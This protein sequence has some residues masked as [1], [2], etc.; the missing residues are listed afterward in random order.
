MPALGRSLGI[1]F[2]TGFG[3]AGPPSGDAD[4]DDWV[5]RVVAAG[6]TVPAATKTA[7]ATFVTAA[8]AHGYW[9][10][11]NRI[12]LFAGGE[13]TACLIP[14]K[15]G[16]GS[17]AEQNVGPF[18]SGDYTQA[19]GLTGNGTTKY[20]RTNLNPGGTLVANDTHIAVYSRRGTADA[21]IHG[22]QTA[23]SASF[24]FQCP[25]GA[26]LLIS[27]QYNTTNGAG[28]IEGAIAAPYGLCIGSRTAAG[29]HKIY[30]AGTQ[31]ATN[32]GSGGGLPGG[33]VWIFALSNSGAPFGIN[34][35]PLAGYSVGAGLTGANVTDY[36]ADLQ[37]FQT[38][39]GRQV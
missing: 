14:L 20:L 13:L 28:H 8:K 24:T 10:K 18:V 31:I 9:T 22:S 1:A 27:E 34:S 21:G 4:V 35:G 25:Q 11:L 15:V 38:S 33:D 2:P 32:A 39:L 6:G 37:A 5:V 23:A 19:T 17:A 36:T 12:N 30:K 16:G 3:A 29:S 26:G 7:A